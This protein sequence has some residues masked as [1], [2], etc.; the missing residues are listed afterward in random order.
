MKK[1]FLSAMSVFVLSGCFG[2]SSTA[3]GSEE[4]VEA[5]GNLVREGVE[6]SVYGSLNSASQLDAFDRSKLSSALEKAKIELTSVRTTRDDPDSSRQFCSADVRIAF[7]Q[8]ILQVVDEARQSAELET[9]KQISN[10]AGLKQDAS[11]FT[12]T[13]EYSV[14]PTDDGEQIIAESDGASALIAVLGELFSSFMLSDEI[15]AANIEQ[16]RLAAEEEARMR[17][18]EEAAEQLYQ[19]QMVAESEYE[20]ALLEE[21]KAEN[22]LAAQRISAV[23]QA[24]PASTREQLAPMQSAWNKKTTARCKVEAAGSST[25]KNMVRAAQM[26]CETRAMGDRVRELERYAEY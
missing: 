10:R 11:G 20:Q 13:I 1:I 24:V 21:A 8:S 5:V 23:W 15:R 16:S 18:E 9:R 26:R 12:E 7:P 3:C 6:D 17:A 19:E 4:A 25:E 14:Q 2:G 22:Q